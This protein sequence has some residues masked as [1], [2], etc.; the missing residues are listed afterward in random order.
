V[1][2]T[3][4]SV[5]Y[6]KQH[7]TPTLTGVRYRLSLSA[8]AER[9]RS[10]F[11]TTRSAQPGGKNA[12]GRHQRLQYHY[13]SRAWFML[14]ILNVNAMTANWPPLCESH[15]AQPLAHRLHTRE[16]YP[17]RHDVSASET[18]VLGILRVSC[19]PCERGSLTMVEVDRSTFLCSQVEA[20]CSRPT[21]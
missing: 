21:Q 18:L 15:T 20:M 9:C 14:Q 19:Q 13:T 6:R 17:F 2:C 3:Q 10:F 4:S 1:E 7:R 11:H 8:N 16:Y 5:P 12:D